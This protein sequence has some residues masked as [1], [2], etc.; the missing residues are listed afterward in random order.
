MGWL[1]NIAYRLRI[2]L[3]RGKAMRAGTHI[4]CTTQHP[5]AIPL[6]SSAGA[7]EAT[8]LVHPALLALGVP[9]EDL[10]HQQCA[11]CGPM[12]GLNPCPNLGRTPMHTRNIVGC[13]ASCFSYDLLLALNPNRFTTW[14]SWRPPNFSYQG[15]R[16]AGRHLTPG[17]LVGSP[18]TAL[19]G[20]IGYS[21]QLGSPS[22]LACLGMYQLLNKQASYPNCLSS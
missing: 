5:A 2:T 21:T 12:C 13:Q 8:Y 4:A 22:S 16:K 9:K 1:H 19:Q 14:V 15:T 3:D 7:M 20:C 17:Q 11:C 10:H 6:G 18:Q